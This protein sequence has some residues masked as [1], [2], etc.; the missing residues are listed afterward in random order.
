[1]PESIQTWMRKHHVIHAVAL[2]LALFFFAAGLAA[3]LLRLDTA[4][5]ARL[6]L[7]SCLGGGAT[8]LLLA[9]LLWRRDVTPYA[10]LSKLGRTLNEEDLTN[11][12]YA[13]TELAQGNLAVRYQVSSQPVPE[14]DGGNEGE[15]ARIM[16]GMVQNLKNMSL[17]FNSLTDVPCRRLCY[18]GADS[19]L[20]GQKCGEV[21]GEMLGGRGKI[22]VTTG[23]FT[24]TGLELR[25]K[26]FQCVMRERFPDIEIVHIFE[27]GE[28]PEL[29]F[30]GTLE[31]IAKHPHLAGIYVTEGATPSA[32]AQAVKESGKAGQIRVIG[33]D[34]TEESVFYIQ[35]GTISATLG[36]NPFAQGHDPVIHLFNHLVAGW[37]PSV[38][39][40]LTTMEVI[41]ASNVKQFW[42]IGKGMVQSQ[43]AIH[44]MA[45]PMR[46]MPRNPL[47]LAVIGREDSAFWTPVKNGVLQAARE[48]SEYNTSVDWII[49]E[50][51]M[52]F[53]DFS[54]AVY[55][56]AIESLLEKG[57]NGLATCVTDRALVPFINR[58]VERG[59]PVI[60]FN[61]EP[62]SLRSLVATIMTQA[63]NLMGVSEQLAA[64]T[65]QVSTATSHINTTMGEVARGTVQ[66]N[67]QIKR[68]EEDL[69][70]LLGN[71]DRVSHE[72]SESAVSA[73]STAK[74]VHESTTAMDRTIGTIQSI[75][76]SVA[77]TGRVIGELSQ[78]S[79]RIDVAVELIDDIAS[80]VN[81]LALNASIEATRAGEA[82]KG[83]MV[84]ANEIRRL[85]KRT[86]EAT[87]EVNE[88]ISTVQR[89]IVNV[90]KSME[91]GLSRVHDSAVMT[92]KA[93]ALLGGI[94]DLVE[95]NQARMNKIASAISN[96]QR[97]SHQVGGAMQNVASVSGRNVQAV[98]D[99]NVATR[100][101]SDQFTDVAGLAQSLEVISQSQ[102]K[103]LA[104]F[105]VS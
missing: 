11:L 8:A 105:T 14:K 41:D 56:E 93:K 90:Q 66:Q 89:G 6:L 72:A 68:T 38:P 10:R 31:A 58:A 63:G 18:V 84:V 74:A 34:I 70:S 45:H 32:V 80:M 104:K 69:E 48:L 60:T 76:Q 42:E 87:R 19:F 51:S 40:L 65:V 96:M 44:E 83:F 101:L 61:S 50:R 67:D 9:F 3:A 22:A 29:A 57:Y 20:E 95:A 27:N 99:I 100:Q 49:P 86:A 17:E 52:R 82:G 35:D 92:D 53:K 39:R 23:S 62:L 59:V 46:Q 2:A 85:A 12:T 4:V 77:E 33:H 47:R 102:Q 71:I 78:H 5:T 16:N 43:A 103:L 81:V 25:R 64:S 13:V 37:Q 54:A 36:Q 15:L 30:K 97:L 94:R 73:E 98:E 79:E 55:G 24:S 75:E 88:L 7:A 91:E 28:K 26:G 1:M 21:M